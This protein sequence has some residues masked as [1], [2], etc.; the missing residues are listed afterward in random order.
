MDFI[1]E[2]NKRIT[3]ILNDLQKPLELF[4]PKPNYLEEYWFNV[5]VEN[6][7]TVDESEI[8]FEK[9]LNKEERAKIEA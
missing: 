3:E 5:S 1:S 9:Y 8:P 2:R 7:L 4:I 6:V